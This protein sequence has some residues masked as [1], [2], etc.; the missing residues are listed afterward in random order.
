MN[1]NANK[2]VRDLAVELPGATGVF[3]KLGIDY[4]CKG[5]QQLDDACAEAGIAIKEVIELVE[6]QSHEVIEERN[7]TTAAELIKYI[8][9]KHHSFTKTEIARLRLLIDKVCDVHGQNHPELSRVRSVFQTLSA[10]LVPHMMKEECVLFPHIVRMEAAENHNHPVSTPPFRT[11]A[12]PV[13]TMKLEHEGAGYLLKQM[14]QITSD[15]SVPADACL[16]YQSL[17][18]ALEAFEKG[19]HQH[20][21]LENNILFPRALEMEMEVGVG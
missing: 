18:E 17:Y 9:D 6:K 1:L 4:C 3:E 21:H 8:I 14:R 11:V 2:T 16:S 7:Y 5:N 13:G 19:L 15:Y 20:I 10:E 12:N